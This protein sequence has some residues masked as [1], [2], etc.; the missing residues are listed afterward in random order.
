[1]DRDEAERLLKG[2]EEGIREWNRRR[3]EGADPPSMRRADLTNTDLTEAAMHGMDLHGADF[4]D[5]TLVRVDL[6]GS[7]LGRVNLFGA[8]LEGADLSG[9]DLRYALVAHANLADAVLQGARL[10]NANLLGTHMSRT[11]LRDADLFGARFHHSHFSATDFQNARC[12][13]TVFA[14]VDL[15]EVRGIE[16]IRHDGPSSISADTIYAS[17]GR[18]PEVFLRGCGVPDNLIQHIPSLTGAAIEFYSCFISYS[19]ADK[20]FARRLRDALQ[21]KGIRCW[22]D[23]H[24][25]LPGDDIHE[26][27]DR[28]IRLWDRVL[29]CAS[30]HSLTSWWVDNEIDTAFDKERRLM[31]ERGKKTLALIPLDLDGY[32]FDKWQSGKKSQVLS[33]LAADFRG[34]DRDNAK[35]EQELEKVVRALRTD[36]GARESPPEPRL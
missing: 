1:M 21:G 4:H 20:S 18:I 8:D 12:W 16:S 31:K 3:I 22:L 14:A 19:H 29:L 27:V 6:R 23:K 7:V 30:E 10:L 9:A 2:G 13:L 32:I 15:R 36:A 17:G 24:Q 34:W 35:F 11:V 5:A 26:Q 33:R 25:M 28:G